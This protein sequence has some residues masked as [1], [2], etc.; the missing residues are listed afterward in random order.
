LCNFHIFP[1]VYHIHQ[2][3][4]WFGKITQTTARK[5]RN[6]LNCTFVYLKFILNHK[7]FAK[8][9]KNQSCKLSIRIQWYII[10]IILIS[11]LKI[12]TKTIST[13]TCNFAVRREVHMQRSGSSL[14]HSGQLGY[15]I[16]LGGNH[17]HRNHPHGI[18]LR[19][20]TSTTCN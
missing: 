18:R 9:L 4:K 10:W 19:K 11:G 16:F 5:Y 8:S 13:E 14:L 3:D 12:N 20:S 7:E 6:L 2:T 15:F 17:T 1:M